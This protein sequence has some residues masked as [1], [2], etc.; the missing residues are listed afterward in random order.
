MADNAITWLEPTTKCNMTCEGCYRENDPMGDRPLK[1]VI[2]ELEQVKKIRKT[3]G[4]SIAGGEPLLYPHIV[5]LVTYVADQGWKPIII[6]NGMCITKELVRN[7]KRAG[8]VAFT[9]HV[10]SHQQRPEWKGKSETELNELR[11]RLAEIIHDAG[12]GRISCGFNATI[13]PDTLNEIPMLTR[14][15]QSH[16]DVVHTMVYILFRQ[17]S[18]D[19]QFDY[20]V[21]GRQIDPEEAASL[22]YL[23]SDSSNY[24]NIMT[25]EVV[26]LIRETNPDY[27]PCAFLNS[28]L[29]GNS[30]K[31]LLGIRI[32]RPDKILGYMDGKFVEIVQM[33][34]HMIKGTYVA[35]ARPGLTGLA[36]VLFPLAL[37]NK[38]MF[39]TFRNWLKEPSKWFKRVC[40]QSIMIIQPPDILEDGRQAMCD[41]CPDSMYYEGE[42]I[43]KCRLDEIQ[44]FGSFIQCVPG[45]NPPR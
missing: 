41:G 19:P 8:L 43:W 31:W 2:G 29:D 39:N 5:D 15:A 44:K 45:K 14:W 32:G 38:G 4:I 22:R 13:Y 24:R 1:D 27:E 3:G 23:L 25:Q 11:L 21:G 16:M 37:L 36:Q 40:L 30:P 7:L 6:S 10:D 42:M 9:V 34:H 12:E 20:F 33:L 18:F 28:S 17:A 26:D 35:Y